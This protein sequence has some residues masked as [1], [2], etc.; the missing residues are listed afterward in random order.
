MRSDR[1]L[2]TELERN[3]Q[4]VMNSQYNLCKLFMWEVED[5]I[6]VGM[7]LSKMLIVPSLE[8]TTYK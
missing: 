8:I 7:A 6:K 4:S 1:R 2:K 3:R 5:S